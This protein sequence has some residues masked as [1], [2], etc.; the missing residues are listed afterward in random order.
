MQYSNFIKTDCSVTILFT[1]ANPITIRSDNPAFDDAVDA[2]ENHR[3]SDIASIVDK[4]ERIATKTN[5][6]FFV[7][8]CVVHC[9]DDALP[10]SLSNMLFRIIDDDENAEA[11]KNFWLNLKENPSARSQ[12]C[13]YDFLA[14][15]H[16][17]VT[18]DGCFVTYKAVRKDY[19]DIHSN[20][21]DN[22]V[23]AV[24]KMDRSKVDDDPQSTCS[25]G[26]HVASYEY[27]A[28]TF[29]HR[30]SNRLMLVKVNPRDVVCVPYDYNNTKI[31][32]CEYTVI[33]EIEEFFNGDDTDEIKD[34]VY[35]VDGDYEEYENGTC[36]ECGCPLEEYEDTVCDPCADCI[37]EEKAPV[38][39]AQS[40][41]DGRLD[42]PIEALRLA[43]IKSG[44]GVVITSGRI[45]QTTVLALADYITNPQ[46]G[47]L[48]VSVRM[49]NQ[50]L[51]TNDVTEFSFTPCSSGIE[52]DP[53]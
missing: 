26:L 9:G 52:V 45:E 46:T 13:L 49:L 21:I 50:K 15:N 40:T 30:G 31:R 14:A 17:C 16:C 1:D 39:Y 47:R 37:E 7:K 18:Q 34:T 32:A 53:V 48:R 3:Y 5:N 38:F 12:K 19:K 41:A 23:G 35:H 20:S 8:D 2:L 29:G 24:V 27:A 22:S 6:E 42:V 10:D 33:S 28:N 36:A 4:A 25:T 43:G 44:N 51:G 11:L